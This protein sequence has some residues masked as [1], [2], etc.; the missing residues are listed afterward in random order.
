MNKRREQET[1]LHLTELL[2]QDACKRGFGHAAGEIM[3]FLY[4]CDLWA[5]KELSLKISTLVKER[6]TFKK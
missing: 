4:G 1:S 3:R 6:E 2:I 5:V